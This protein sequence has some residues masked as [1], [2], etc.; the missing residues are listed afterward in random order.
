MALGQILSELLSNCFK[1]AFAGR[2]SGHIQVE[3][4]RTQDK[5]VELT[6]K[7]DGNG[8]PNNFNVQETDTLGL[9]LVQGLAQQLRG[10]ISIEKSQG[11]S[12]KVCIEQGVI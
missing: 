10:E 5:G 1:H 12:V 9:K 7:D 4:L 2:E 6:V 8:F 3:L 11:A